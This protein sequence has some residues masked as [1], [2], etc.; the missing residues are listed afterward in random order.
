[1][2]GTEMKRF[3]LLLLV[4]STLG[5]QV[6]NLLSTFSPTPTARPRPTATPPVARAVAAP[7]P[8]IPPS[9]Q[10]PPPVTAT[11]RGD[12]LRVRAAPN[13][14]AAIVDRLNRGDT[15]QVVGRNATNDWLQILLPR[16]PNAR[17]WISAAYADLS[18]P[19]DTLP[20]VPSE[21]RPYP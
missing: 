11:I 17:G 4:A 9:T 19:I 13:T 10:P 8:T 18:A 1:M 3:L 15:V 7:E 20:L 6:T 16:D 5:C 14:N 12:S 2:Q 21:T